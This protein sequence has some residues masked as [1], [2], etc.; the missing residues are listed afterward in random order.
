MVTMDTVYL[1]LQTPVHRHSVFTF[2]VRI[3]LSAPSKPL[4]NTRKYAFLSRLSA[5]FATSSRI[6]G[7]L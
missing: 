6:P 1:R 3:P 4:P 2:P 7:N 5:P